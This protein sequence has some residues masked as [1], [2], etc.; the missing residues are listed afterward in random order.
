M[1]LG[2]DDVRA[3][4][5]TRGLGDGGA[6]GSERGGDEEGSNEMGEHG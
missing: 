5:R 2:E 4:S 1:M 6:T 3:A